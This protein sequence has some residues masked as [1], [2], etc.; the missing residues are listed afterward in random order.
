MEEERIVKFNKD[1]VFYCL[2]NFQSY[3]KVLSTVPHVIVHDMVLVFYLM[4][5]V[6]EDDKRLAVII[7]ND[8]LESLEISDREIY[9]LAE[10]NT[11]RMFPAEI[12][13]VYTAYDSVHGKGSAEK[14]LGNPENGNI[15]YTITNSTGHMGANVILYDNLNEDNFSGIDFDPAVKSTALAQ[16]AAKLKDNLLVFPSSV[17]EF[18]VAPAKG[19]II[20]YAYMLLDTGNATCCGEGEVLSNTLFYYDRNTESLTPLDRPEE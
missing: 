2:E 8:L 4:T 18:I 3:K 12:T 15:L 14:D 5:D 16:I 11:P 20:E 9:K 13:D 1:N 7:T 10:K 6:E 17:H 19:A